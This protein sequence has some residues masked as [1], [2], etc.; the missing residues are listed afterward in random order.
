MSRFF[1]NGFRQALRDRNEVSDE[2][3]LESSLRDIYRA[4]AAGVVRF[5]QGLGD[6]ID[7]AG[8]FLGTDFVDDWY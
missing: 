1:T 4:P 7:T 8:E 2:S 6:L 3:L 5:G